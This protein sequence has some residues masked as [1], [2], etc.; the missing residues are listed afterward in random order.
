MESLTNLYPVS[1]TLRFSLIP[2]NETLHNI[3]KAGILTEDEKLAEDFKKVKKIADDWLKNFINESLTGASLNLEDL[4]IFEEKYNLF[5]RNEKDEEEFINIKTKLRK[6]I[7]S[8]LTKNPKFKLLG[9][10]DLIRKELPEFV[11]TEEEKD[12][13]NKFKNFT[14]YFT[15]YNQTRKNIYSDEEKHASY[16]YRIIHENLPLFIINKKNFNTIKTSYPE[17]INDIKKTTEPLLDNTKIEDMFSIE[18]FSNTLTQPGIDLYNKMIGGESLE[19]G[20]KIQGF[21]E[22]VNLFRQA[23]KLDGKSVPMIKQLRKQI[24]GNKNT[25]EWIT[26]GFKDKNS[27]NEA[28]VKFIKNTEH[29]KNNLINKLFIKNKPYDYNKIFI[30]NRFIANIS[31]EL[32]KDW[33]LLKNNMLEQYKS[34][35]PK[36]KN[37]EKEFAK[38]PYFSIA[39]IQKSI[40]NQNKHFPDFIIDHFH[41]KIMTLIPTEKKIHELWKGNKDS[42]PAL[43]N[44]MDYY[45]ELYRISKPFDVDCADKD[46]VFYELF[47]EI[48]NDFSKVVKLYNEVRNFITKKPY[49]LEKIKLNFG[50]STLLS[51][52]DVNKETDNTAVLLQKNGNY[53]LAIMNKDHNKIFKNTPVT[54]NEKNSYK[55]MEY[56]LLPKSYMMLPKVFFTKGNKDKYEPSEEIIRIYEEKTFKTGDNFNINDLHKL[57]DFYKESVKKNPEWSCYNFNFKPTKE[58]Q[59]I[60]EFYE[61]TDTQGYNITFKNIPAEYI[62]NLV[63]KGQLYL[64]KIYSKD[65]SSYSKGTPNLHTL[66]FKMLFDDRNLKNTVYKLN[67]GAEIFYRKKSVTYPKNIMEKGHHAEDLKGKFNYPIIKDRRFTFDKFQFNISITL[68][69]NAQGH[70]NINDI[71]RNLIKSNNT[72][73]IGIHRAENHLIYITVLNSSGDIIEQ[74]SLNEI[75]SYGDKTVNYMEKLT[76]RGKERNDA[77]INWET[78]GNIKELKEGYL[79]NVISEIANIMIKYN[80]ICV[81]EDLNY[82]FIRERSAIEKQIY[83][84]FEKMLIDKL[85]FYV[86]KK[87]SP[88]ETSGILKPLQ[89]ANKF[90][91]FE[92]IGKESGMIFYVSPYKITDI[93][94]VTGFVNLFDTRYFNI[95]KAIQ[96]FDKFDD[97]YYNAKTDLFGFNFDYDNFINKEKIQ[98]TKTKWTVYSYGERIERFNTNNIPKFKKIDLTKEF[99]NLF[100][101]YSINYNSNLKKSII[102]L[103]DKNF[104]MKLLSLFRLTVQMRN[105]DFIIS[106]VNDNLGNFFDS[107]NSDNKTLPENTA[108]NGAYNI[109]R[110]GLILLNRIKQTSDIRKTNL[111]ISGDEWLQYTQNKN[112]Y[113]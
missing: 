101:E 71:C 56:K 3:E 33:N 30:K 15:N 25:P 28:I 70:G 1:K 113:I 47:D 48:F 58:Y 2:Q 35:N 16:A 40:P 42:I 109:A 90:T 102:S 49:S 95:E 44:L 45:L 68:N 77:R 11:K 99:K 73:I 66:Y 82:D 92:K 76:E 89:L 4:L 75:K 78:I 6:E 91:T 12:I 97:I 111:K 21:N 93:D 112:S 10:A 63:K 55:K 100:S 96:F 86:D 94:P 36:S 105:G 41:D 107:R 59:K 64:F 23:N 83:Q 38:I 72:N 51:G 108:A 85:N 37:P 43:K 98:N 103:K 79:S 106:P 27:M 84:K 52:W 62:D 7:V 34:K 65:F 14:T 54:K 8:Y 61:E 81:M 88:E 87:K 18:W 104:F 31:H 53:Y 32:F 29:A 9:T 39:E 50:N 24:L 17:L 20:K 46:P 60:N 74:R 26:E 69:P 19:N 57:I 22:K 13:I 110:K 80:A 67:G 5:P